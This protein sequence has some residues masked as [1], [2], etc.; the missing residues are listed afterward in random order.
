MSMN[1]TYRARVA[2]LVSICTVSALAACGGGDGT[3]TPIGAPADANVVPDTG[4]VGDEHTTPAEGVDASKPDSGRA[5]AT[6]NDAADACDADATE[7]D[8]ATDASFDGDVSVDAVEASTEAGRLDGGLDGSDQDASTGAIDASDSATPPLGNAAIRVANM[9]GRVH[10]TASF[11]FCLRS[12]NGTFGAPFMRTANKGFPFYNWSVSTYATVSAGKT[13]V[14]LVSAD[15]ANCGKAL[16][17]TTDFV[18]D[19]F[20]DNDHAT[21]IVTDDAS[22]NLTMYAVRDSLAPAAQG[23]AALRF[24]HVD[25][26]TGT[27][28]VSRGAGATA[29]PALTGLV[30]DRVPSAANAVAGGPAVDGLGYA[31]LEPNGIYSVARQD[32]ATWGDFV[33]P[34]ST[35]STVFIAPYGPLSCPEGSLDSS[36]PEQSACSYMS[37]TTGMPDVRILNLAQSLGP[38]DIC[39]RMNGDSTYPAEAALHHAGNR[40]GIGYREAGDYLPVPKTTLTARVVA[41][42]AW[43]DCNAATPIAEIPS[44]DSSQGTLVLQVG[45][46]GPQLDAYKSSSFSTVASPFATVFLTNLSPSGPAMSLWAGTTEVIRGVH[47]LTEGGGESGTVGIVHVRLAP[48]DAVPTGGSDLVLANQTSHSFFW[49]AAGGNG[50]PADTLVR[51]INTAEPSD[52]KVPC[53]VVA[54]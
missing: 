12:E 6:T 44:F 29:V 27:L 9:T 38:V 42:S 37:W 21:L 10:Q 11:D 16:A 19:A 14:R 20:A 36:Y 18:T 3:G 17:G 13:V 26:S 41:A 24:I 39:V 48:I 15:A 33:A 49:Y 31:S 47:P 4:A 23:T 45:P 35:R 7:V 1:R 32:G 43:A 28:T 50:A 40:S 51:C 5:D 34:V 52:F 46:N 53:D 2:A 22:P 25:S 54:P 8:V 30:L